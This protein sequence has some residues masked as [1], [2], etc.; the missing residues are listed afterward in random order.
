M[1]VKELISVLKNI[2]GDL[3]VQRHAY[4]GYVIDM[5]PTDMEVV[6]WPGRKTL[7]FDR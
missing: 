2:D 6:Q 3:E 7:V 5:S 4:S 1:T